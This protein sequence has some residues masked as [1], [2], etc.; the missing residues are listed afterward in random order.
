MKF[1]LTSPDSF[2]NNL[3]VNTNKSFRGHTTLPLMK[4]SNEVAMKDERKEQKKQKLRPLVA[5][6]FTELGYRRATTAEIARRCGVQEPTLYRLW[7]GKKEM[8]LD[9]LDYVCENLL[10]VWQRELDAGG[11]DLKRIEKLLNYEST[12]F[13]E[14]GNYSIIFSCL[15]EADDPEIREALQRMY[16]RIHAFLVEQI[17]KFRADSKSEESISVPLSAWALI[18][19]GTMASISRH[20]GLMSDTDRE[21]FFREVGGQF[22]E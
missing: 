11:N 6:A 13:G 17:A 16:Y 3:I 1:A 10:A 7:P 20:L 9:T 18:A 5:A 21:S 22:F 12:H 15:S 2:D 4:N 8:V 19:T 14:L